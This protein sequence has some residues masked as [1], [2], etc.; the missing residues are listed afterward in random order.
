MSGVISASSLIT[1]PDNTENT[2]ISDQ[3][4]DALSSYQSELNAAEGSNSERWKST[5]SVTVKPL[6]SGEKESTD[7]L[8]P[9]ESVT[10]VLYGVDGNEPSQRNSHLRSDVGVQG[11]TETG[12]CQEGSD[13]GGREPAPANNPPASIPSISQDGKPDSM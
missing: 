8:P 11:P 1:P 5:L 9:P 2:A 6:C 13:V 7:A 10:G 3:V 4:Q 12:P